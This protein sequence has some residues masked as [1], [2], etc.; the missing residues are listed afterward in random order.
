MR[1]VVVLLACAFWSGCSGCARP[2]VTEENCKRTCDCTNAGTGDELECTMAF[3]CK[4]P[5]EDAREKVCEADYDIECDELCSRY[6]A[7]AACGSKRCEADSNCEKKMTC[8]VLDANGD[9]SGQ[10]FDCVIPFVCS[11]D[12]GVCEPSYTVPDANLCTTCCLSPGVP[13]CQVLGVSC[14]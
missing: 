1:L 14:E 11:A 13:C 5:T 6:A 8:D 10:K 9:P 2:C 3:Q 12:V 7:N 4:E